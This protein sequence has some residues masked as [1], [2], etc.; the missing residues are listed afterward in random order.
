MFGANSSIPTDFLSLMLTQFGF[1]HLIII[2][3][4]FLDME[5]R[6]LIDLKKTNVTA[7][8]TLFYFPFPI[9]VIGNLVRVLF[10][11]FQYLDV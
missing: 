1:T 10:V 7:Q 11:W 6:P 8:S 3:W 9:T 5:S 2:V 4:D